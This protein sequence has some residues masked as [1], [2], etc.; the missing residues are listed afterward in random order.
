MNA[1]TLQ[2]ISMVL[3]GVL[4]IVPETAED[5]AL[6]REWIAFCKTIVDENRDPTPQEELEAERFAQTQHDAIQGS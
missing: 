3:Q 6:W 2:L 5:Y 1:A 4:R